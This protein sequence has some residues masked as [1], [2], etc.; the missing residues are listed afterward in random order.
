MT[1][2]LTDRIKW[3]NNYCENLG[4]LNENKFIIEEGKNIFHL[5]SGLLDEYE[6]V[7]RVGGGVPAAVSHLDPEFS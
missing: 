6:L 2:Q 7:R 4:F 3:D 1:V 5:C